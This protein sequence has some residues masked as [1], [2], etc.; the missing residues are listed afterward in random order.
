MIIFS[1]CLPFS[2]LASSCDDWLPILFREYILL[3][4]CIPAL[5]SDFDS[6]LV[7]I[8]LLL[9]PLPAADVWPGWSYW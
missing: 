5:S 4:P 7:H 8:T 6:L 2:S 1:S 9:Y 3:C